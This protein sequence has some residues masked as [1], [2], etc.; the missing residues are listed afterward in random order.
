MCIVAQRVHGLQCGHAG[1]HACCQLLVQWVGRR[2]VRL[3]LTR[4]G[5]GSVAG[6][7]LCVCRGMLGYAWKRGLQRTPRCTHEARYTPPRVSRRQ[8]RGGWC[9]GCG[10]QGAAGRPQKRLAADVRLSWSAVCATAAAALRNTKPQAVTSC[11][12][13][14]SSCP[15][16]LLRLQQRPF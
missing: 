4:C 2:R 12:S 15:K 16:H 6:H 11:D 5:D 10:R 7:D 3:V 8:M 13:V 9:T 14:Q 1:I